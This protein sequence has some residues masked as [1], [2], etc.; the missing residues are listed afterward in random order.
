MRL[1]YRTTGAVVD[2]K[3]VFDELLGFRLQ[4]VDGLAGEPIEMTWGEVIDGYCLA[5]DV[6]RATE[7]ELAALR[8]LGFYEQ[9]NET[10]GTS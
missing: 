9:S 6:V 10:G 2:A 7:A 3:I 1:R 5:C 8:K 4:V